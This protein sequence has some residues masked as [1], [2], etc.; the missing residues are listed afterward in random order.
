M[1]IVYLV[2]HNADDRT[3]PPQMENSPDLLMCPI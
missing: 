1:T 2:V 3:D